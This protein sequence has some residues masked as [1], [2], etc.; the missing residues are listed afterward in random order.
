MKGT[1]GTVR[2]FSSGVLASLVVGLLTGF[3]ASG[4]SP[5]DRKDWIQ[6]FN[7]RNLDG[8]V[9]KIK[10]YP[11]GENFGETFRVENGLL[12]V[13]Y[14]KYDQ[15]NNRFG[16]LF[17]K[18]KFSYYVIAAEYSLCRP[19]GARRAGLGARNNGLMLHSQAPETM[20]KDQDFP[21][22][23]EAQLLGDWT[24]ERTA[25]P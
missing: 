17:Y 13:V 12:R 4:Q 18:D 20:G 6:L 9:P 3:S 5:A 7:G 22:S 2:L 21:I 23:I 15:F 10:G 16:H 14:D 25:P 24:T 1:S 19:A 11:L 8:W